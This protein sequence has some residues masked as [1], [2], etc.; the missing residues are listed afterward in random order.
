MFQIS[1]NWG[2]LRLAAR[3]SL[4]FTSTLPRSGSC[5]PTKWAAPKSTYIRQTNPKLDA[6][7]QFASLPR[8]AYLLRIGWQ[9]F[10]WLRLSSLILIG[11]LLFLAACHRSS[12]PT[13]QELTVAAAADLQ[14]AFEEI[15]RTFQSLHQVKVTFSFGSS[16]MLTRQIENGA[17]VDLFAAANTDYVDQLGQEGYILP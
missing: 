3:I 8:R 6:M 12:A 10:L 16:G 5:T 17:P 2:I 9:T 13:E 14:P 1:T 4:L 15:G 11:S 7:Q